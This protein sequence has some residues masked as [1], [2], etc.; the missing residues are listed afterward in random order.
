MNGQVKRPETWKEWKE[1]FEKA[2]KDTE[3]QLELLKAQLKRAV[4]HSR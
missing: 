3:I 4:E 2:V 1:Y